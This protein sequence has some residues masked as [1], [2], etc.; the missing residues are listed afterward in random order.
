MRSSRGTLASAAAAAVLVATFAVGT[1]APSPGAVHLTTGSTAGQGEDIAVP[2]AFISQKSATSQSSGFFSDLI[3]AFQKAMEQAAANA[4][5]QAAAQLPAQVTGV[6]AVAGDSRVNLTWTAP[7]SKK[8]ITGYTITYSAPGQAARTTKV[9]GTTGSLTGL[10]N[11]T[12]YSITVTATSSAGSGPASSAVTSTPST[13]A[14]APSGL[15]ASPGDARFAASWS[16]P[17]QTGGAPITG[18]VLTATPGTGADVVRKVDATTATVTGLTNGIT[19]RVR[20][21]AVN[22]AGTGSTSSSVTVTPLTVAQAPS[23]LA[24][25]SGDGSF[26]ATWN[27]PAETG[28][29]PV[30]GYALTYVTPSGA[31]VVQPV[32]GTRAVVSG[33]SNGVAYKVSVAAITAAGT[34][35]SSAGASALPQAPAPVAPEVT[36]AAPTPA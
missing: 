4:A 23:S 1:H 16:A 26:T 9:T 12:A 3:D 15:S 13:V 11:G 22:A 30:T 17:T 25:D 35:A 20:V 29:A 32:S 33:L 31:P 24:V 8:A 27:A 28:G 14:A 7:S 34:G 21:A 5:A 36:P 19:Y 18:Y 6:T 2:V 10:S